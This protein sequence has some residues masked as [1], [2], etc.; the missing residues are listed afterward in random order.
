MY[1]CLE[2]LAGPRRLH[3][4]T[5][6]GACALRKAGYGP[7]CGA[8]PPFAWPPPPAAVRDRSPSPPPPRVYK[9][10][11]VC[12]D[13]SSGYHYGVSSCE[14]CKGFFRRSIQKSMV[15]T[16][17]RDKNCQIN[18]V[19]RNRC[20]FCRLQKCFEVGM[21]KEAVR[22][23]RN[24]KKKEVKV[25]LGKYTTNSSADHRV[26][27]DLGLWDKFSELATK[28]IIK[29]VEFAKRLPGF[30]ALSMAD[31]ITL[32]K[33]ACLDILM[34]RICTRYT[35]EQDTM[36]FSDG[37]TL[38]RT[39]MH[40]AGFGPL[41]DLVFAFAGQLLPLQMDDTETGLLSAICLI[42]GDRMDLEEPEKVE[43]LQEPLLEALK[44]Y[45]R[46]RRP[47][48]PHMFPRMLMKITDLRG[49]STKGAERAITLKM[50]IP[51][52]MPPS[53]GRCWRTP[54]CSRRRRGRSPPG[55]PQRPGQPPRAP[56]PHSPPPP[57]PIPPH[58]TCEACVRSHPRCAWCEDPLLLRPG[59][60]R[61]FRVRFRRAGGH[62]VDLYY[63][64]DLSYSM[65][66][67]LAHVRRLGRDLLAALRNVTP[68]VRIGFG[69]VTPAAFRHVLAL[70]GDAD[71][72]AERVGRQ[73]VSGNM[74]APEGGL[75]AIM[76]V[77]LCQERI[78][79][80]PATRLL[81]FASDDTFHTAGDGKL[82]GV[83]LPSD[84][85]CHLDASGV[86][87]KSHLYDYPSVGHVAQVLSAANIQP[88]FAVTGPTVP[89][90]QEL[91]RLIPKS[92][93]GELQEDS[94]NVV[95]LIA[96][97][98]NSL[99][100]TVELQHSPLPPA[101]ASA[102]SP[103]A[104]APAPPL[105]R[106]PLLRRPRQ[107]GGDLHGAGAGGRLPGSQPRAPLCHGGTFHC[108]AC[109]CPGGR[110]G[111]RC[112]CEEAAEAGGGVGPPTA[113]GPPAA[114]GAG[115]SAAPA[116]APGLS[117][118]LCQCDSGGCERHGGLVCGGPQRGECVCGTCR[119]REG[120]GGRGCG[121]HGRCVC[122]SCR[123]QPGYG[124]PLCGHC[125]A[126]P[127]PC[128]RLR[129]CADCVALGRGPLRGNCSRACARVT[130]RLL[131]A[132][133]PAPRLVPGDHRG[134]A[135]P[136]LPHRG[137]GAEE[138]E[139]DED[140]E[141]TLTVWVEEALEKLVAGLVAGLVA[142]GLVAL[143]LSRLSLELY[144]RREYRRFQRECQRA[145]WNE[146]TLRQPLFKSATTTTIN[147]RYLPE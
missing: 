61:S 105:P 96:D 108:G 57:P 89:I 49:I 81:L 140:R 141:V 87:A 128:Q 139:D 107:P 103:T 131:P 8:L 39:Q 21:S 99:S 133:P 144:D 56:P 118:S 41:T 37:L 33:A 20:Q 38:N 93:V 53:S 142:L 17:H 120:F 97:A 114:G 104:G 58:A 44:V 80:R 46:R 51:G 94:S 73:R 14:G 143:G 70:T 12:S 9:P 84:T 2:A 83:V 63:L 91:S 126:C 7:R 101:S 117:G 115:A 47:R 113:R 52:P 22:N 55:A 6:R 146:V 98:Y 71:A 60:E 67:D 130:T 111:R 64:M 32:L 35:P 29:I 92:V 48:Q 40:N 54:R 5:N 16:C 34:L 3:D 62:P 79:W 30:T 50:E 136:P 26:Q 106:W 68:S 66:D 119:C 127:T 15:Y 135:R 42:C 82:G 43:K 110:R 69:R 100:S 124:G 137:G 145:R 25:E 4:V 36:T 90:Y 31:Q 27:L 109:S 13:K 28:C 129:D 86:Y 138:E 65:R 123:C 77:A 88:I 18:K 19:T 75:D 85:R 45:A 95:Q 78:G 72:F 24:K 76:Q 10:C 23:D 116:S 59:E 132:A 1:D 74:D 125:P 122:G 134:R 147:P 112:E 102:T 11:F 121:G